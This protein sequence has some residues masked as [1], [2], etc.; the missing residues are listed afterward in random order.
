LALTRRT[1]VRVGIVLAVAVAGLAVTWRVVGPR[2]ARR[3]GAPAWVERISARTRSER[4]DI[5]FVVYDARRRDDFS[6]GPHGNRRGDTPFLVRFAQDALYFPRAIAPGCWTAP[7][8]AAMFSGLG[9]CEL[10]ND[11]YN[12]G[13]ASFPAYF[14]SLAEVLALAGYDTAALADHPYFFN[15]RLEEALVRGFRQFDVINDFE[16]FVF[17][18]NIGTRD[19]AIERRT[20]LAGLPDLTWDELRSAIERFN[21]GE[22]PFG[23]SEM[24]FDA[25]SGLH[26]PRLDGL[27]RASSYFERRYRGTLDDHVFRGG[28]K[29]PFFLFLNL[30]MSEIAQPDPGLFSRWLLETVLVNA[31][32]RHAR[33]QA[34]VNP[35]HVQSWLDDVA[36]RLGLPRG[37]FSSPMPYLKHLFD[38]RFYDATFRSVWEHLEKRGLTQ[39]LLAVVAS[40][41]GVS[42]REHGEDLLQHGGARPFEYITSVPLVIR[43][44]RGSEGERLHGTRSERV[45]LVDLFPTLIE[46]GVGAGVFERPLPVQGRSLMERIRTRDFEPILVSEC[47]LGPTSSDVFPG[48]AGYAKAVYDGDLKLIHAPRLYG[49]PPGAGGWP[50]VVRLA[51]AWTG[52]GPPPSLETL[53]EPLELLYDLG[54]DPHETRNLARA[55]PDDVDRLRRMPGSWACEPLRAGGTAPMW[56]PA[57]RETL[58]ALGYLQ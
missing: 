35:R 40:D 43:F 25:E 6:F 27:Y 3:D 47:S 7:V 4:P 31:R 53:A 49:M 10:G 21:R 33:L 17:I 5:L 45:S 55:R 8:H 26:L 18:T 51:G 32:A 11:Y 41:H 16:R 56:D 39:N 1:S 13:F 28:G 19:G 29:R 9:V 23:P 57:A 30:H 2:S 58:R 37:P 48:T 34:G 22:D 14:Q 24:D 46:A 12:P 36:L 54:S 20:P 50:I 38:N 42:F 52:S 15:P 44:P